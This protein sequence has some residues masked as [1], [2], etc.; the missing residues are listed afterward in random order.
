M[1]I[2][3]RHSNFIAILIAIL[4][5]LTWTCILANKYLTFGYCD[6]DLAFFAQGMWNLIHR[7]GYASIFQKHLFGNHANLIAFLIAPIFAVFQNAFTLILLK[8]MSYTL[9]GYGLFL[10][11]RARVGSGIALWTMIL[12]YVYAPNLFGLLHDFDFE[13]LSPAFLVALLYFFEKRFWRPF[14]VTALLTMLIKEN[15]PLI[16][17]AFGC[18]G[19]IN[20]RNRIAWGVIPMT[21]SIFILIYYLKFFIPLM[22]GGN[23]HA[24]LPYVGN[25]AYIS[26]S[27]PLGAIQHLSDMFFRQPNLSL[28]KDI[29]ACVSFLPLASPYSLFPVAPIFLQHFLS[30]SA[31]EHTTMFYYEMP[32]APF[33]F[34]GFA[35]ATFKIKNLVRPLFFSF[36]CL[37]ITVIFFFHWS[38][39]WPHLVTRTTCVCNKPASNSFPDKRWQLL[40]MIPN[41]APVAASF[42][43][44]AQLSQRREVY[45]FYRLF[46][47]ADQDRRD[48]W[49]LPVHIRYVLVDLNDP[50]MCTQL[51]DKNL[52][53]FTTRQLGSQW[54]LIAT[55]GQSVLFTKTR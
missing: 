5:F 48:P 2:K 53:E 26:T 24:P 51:G 54:K 42:S 41:D 39:T 28:F 15:M 23:I 49:I 45:P 13:S 35:I 30:T 55:E 32:L 12:Y 20:S 37:L 33:I 50:W 43:F 46:S 27:G 4:V 52:L 6:W 29:F 44:L 18:L 7:D 31:T 17:F 36:L 47:P 38:L 10:L 9:A 3:E 8:I 19:L 25:Y 14:I 40:S 11:C 22:F 16:V 1:T 21:L 34:L